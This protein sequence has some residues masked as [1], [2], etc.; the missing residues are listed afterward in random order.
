MVIIPSLRYAQCLLLVDRYINLCEGDAL[1][2]TE[3]P[4]QDTPLPVEDRNWLDNVSYIPQTT[5][6][7][8]M[9]R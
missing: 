4:K 7:S 1:L 2:G 3:D 9:F 5:G 8:C 6:K